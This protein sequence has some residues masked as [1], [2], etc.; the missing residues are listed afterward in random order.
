MCQKLPEIAVHDYLTKWPGSRQRDIHKS[1]PLW[2]LLEKVD[3]VFFSHQKWVLRWHAF[4]LHRNFVPFSVSFLMLIF[5]LM[6][7]RANF[8]IYGAF[9]PLHIY[10]QLSSVCILVGLDSFRWDVIELYKSYIHVL[11]STR[12]SWVHCTAGVF[13]NLQTLIRLVFHGLLHSWLLNLCK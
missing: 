6:R 8:M 10:T 5:M 9:A 12:T 4:V 7:D 11:L 3:D 13:W 1:P 2:N